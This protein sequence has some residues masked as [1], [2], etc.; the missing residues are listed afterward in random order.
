MEKSGGRP[1]KETDGL[2]EERT[3]GF[4]N[5]KTNGY[6]KEETKTKPNVN[7]NVNVNDNDNVN[8]NVNV[9]DNAVGFY[10]ADVAKID[11]LM[12]EC[13]NTTNINNIRECTG[14][15]DKLP[16]DVIEYVLKK[17]SRIANPNWAYAMSILDDYVKKKITTLE[18]AKADD[19][20]HKSSKSSTKNDIEEST[21]EKNA[22]KLKELEEAMKNDTW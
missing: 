6:E 15:L 22:R 21:E 17:T 1:K 12:I 10:D 13:L 9:N 8:V 5:K 2:Q 3:N 16:I 20:N 14:Y 7:D 18:Q 4:R 11:E 19:L